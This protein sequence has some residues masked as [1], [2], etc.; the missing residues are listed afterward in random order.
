MERLLC[1]KNV[2][3]AGGARATVSLCYSSVIG[4]LA[5]LLCLL[6]QSSLGQEYFCKSITLHGMALAI[7]LTQLCSLLCS[8]RKYQRM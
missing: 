2:H 8:K 3:L 4:R 1:K 7:N 5:V 6:L